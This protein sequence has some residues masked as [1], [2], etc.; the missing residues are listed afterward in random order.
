MMIAAVSGKIEL[1]ILMEFLF[2]LK[3]YSALVWSKRNPAIKKLVP[4]QG[5]QCPGKFPG[6][7]I[8]SFVTLFEMIQF[9]QNGYRYDD[10]IVGKLVVDLYIDSN[11]GV[12]RLPDKTL[13]LLGKKLLQKGGCGVD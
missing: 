6:V 12:Y 5:I 8:Y 13:C 7:K 3:K 2:K 1:K 9:F 4:A 11:F 10:I